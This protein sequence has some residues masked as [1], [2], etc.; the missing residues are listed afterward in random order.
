M[1]KKF[2]YGAGLA[3]ITGVL[4]L[5]GC[6]AQE[7]DEVIQ[8]ENEDTQESDNA[9]QTEDEE[10][11]EYQESGMENDKEESVYVLADENGVPT[12][13]NVTVTLKNRGLHTDITDKTM[14]KNLKNSKGDETATDLG[15][16]RYEWENHGED[17]CYKGEADPSTSLPVSL[18]ITYYLD[19]KETPASELAG[20]DGKITMR[21]D[22]TNHTKEQGDM[23]P[24]VVLTG[25]T[26]SEEHARNIT[27][28]NGEVQYLDGDYLIY[29]MLFPG[30]SEELAL[31]ELELTKEEEIDIP[32]YMEVSFGA[33]DF[34]LEFTATMYSNGILEE[35]KVDKITDKLDELADKL[36][37]V[38]TTTGNLKDKVGQLKNGGSSLRQGAETLSAGLEQLDATLAELAK[39]D[40]AAY[41]A[42]SAQVTQL[43]QG[44]KTLSQGISTYTQGADKACDNIGNSD[45]ADKAQD[46]RDISQKL[47]DMKKA[48]G[49][50]YNFSGI[51]EGKTGS[52]SFIIETAEIKKS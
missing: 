39:T 34:E 52:V 49:D 48:S 17:I 14:L 43:S 8:T 47:K 3:L 19:G 27:V 44:G 46:I 10:A 13:I 23:V 1:K 33:T 32:D 6:K 37:K 20:A 40:P 35:D 42:L 50:Y 21:F 31:Q 24:F 12:E 11:Y 18:E 38:S 51:E 9:S 29:G 5:G 30:V 28:E 45:Y 26:L 15:D 2:W 7:K 22:Y 36:G 4:I 25:L 41:A 16:G